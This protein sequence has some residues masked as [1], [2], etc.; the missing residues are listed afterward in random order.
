MGIKNASRGVGWRWCNRSKIK[1]KLRLSLMLAK[2]KFVY[3]KPNLRS[4]RSCPATPYAL[5][6][7]KSTKRLH[8]GY[9]RSPEKFCP[10]LALKSPKGGNPLSA[11]RNFSGKLDEDGLHHLVFVNAARPSAVCGIN[12][13][14]RL[15]ALYYQSRAADQPHC[16]LR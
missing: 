8:D 10:I 9:Y 15:W 1:G 5:P 13:V 2:G 14:R 11:V 6:G 16:L 12:T 4:L 7:P 3:T